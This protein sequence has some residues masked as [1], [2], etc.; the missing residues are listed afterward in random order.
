MGIAPKM[1][2]EVGFFFPPCICFVVHCVCVC[3]HASQI[4]P[5]LL[6]ESVLSW[7]LWCKAWKS[8]PFKRR[9]YILTRNMQQQR[10]CHTWGRAAAH[11]R[12]L[13][14]TF[15]PFGCCSCTNF[16]LTESS[17]CVH[18]R[19]FLP[20]LRFIFLLSTFLRR[21]V[22]SFEPFHLTLV[23]EF[24]IW[25]NPLNHFL[26]ENSMSRRIVPSCLHI[27]KWRSRTR[28]RFRRRD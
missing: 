19:I 9:E 10:C 8:N 13:L 2:R 4:R 16:T 3:V 14:V 12:H 25:G 22:D 15:P 24:D 21:P 18:A 1:C 26:A 27:K 7:G 20:L 23:E 6:N 11:C 28:R 17:W 5:F